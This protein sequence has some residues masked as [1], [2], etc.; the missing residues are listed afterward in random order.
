MAMLSHRLRRALLTATSYVNRSISLSPASIA[1]ASDFP[2][3]S[4]VLQR[5]VLGRS[6]E[7]ATRVPV[8]LYSTRQLKLYKEG[9]E[10]TEDTVLFEGCDYNHWLITMDFPKD[11]PK[12]PEEMVSTY[13]Q[14]CAYGLGIRSLFFF[15]F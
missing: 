11:N 6:T 15:F 14:T 8:R 1:P 2:T 10:I 9:D 13:E 7:V 12:S 4:A 5:S 3:V